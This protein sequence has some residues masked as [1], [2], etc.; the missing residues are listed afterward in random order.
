[1]RIALQDSLANLL[2][3]QGIE[4]LEDL[5]TEAAERTS[6]N[7]ESRAGTP[8]FFD[9]D[10]SKRPSRGYDALVFELTGSPNS[11]AEALEALSRQVCFLMH[12][13]LIGCGVTADNL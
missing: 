3:G 7:E 9:F 11:A 5:D 13:L 4:T 10:K 12:L 6:G 2:Q 8:Q 1:M